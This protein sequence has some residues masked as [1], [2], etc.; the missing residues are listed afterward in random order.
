M[1]SKV[2]YPKRRSYRYRRASERKKEI[3]IRKW[4]QL[5]REFLRKLKGGSESRIFSDCADD[6][7]FGVLVY[8]RL[9]LGWR[10]FIGGRGD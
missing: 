2:F 9:S 4:C 10:E 1:V 8:R 5:F 3:D 6:A 7:D